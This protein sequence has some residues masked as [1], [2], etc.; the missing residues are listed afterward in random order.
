[1]VGICGRVRIVDGARTC[2]RLGQV[3]ERALL[4]EAASGPLAE[5]T[6]LRR[7]TA[8]WDGEAMAHPKDILAHCAWWMEVAAGSPLLGRI[9]S[10][11]DQGI[12]SGKDDHRISVM[13][14]EGRISGTGRHLPIAW[15]EAQQRVDSAI[16]ASDADLEVDLTIGDRSM[17][18][19]ALTVLR[20][21]V[22]LSYQQAFDGDAERVAE[23]DLGRFDLVP[24]QAFVAVALARHGQVVNNPH[25]LQ[26]LGRHLMFELGTDATSQA[27][28]QALAA[29]DGAVVAW[30][31]PGSPIPTAT[32]VADLPLAAADRLLSSLGTPRAADGSVTFLAGMVPVSL[33]WRDGRLICT[34]HP[35]GSQPLARTGGF[36][37][38]PEIVRALAQLPT[39]TPSVCLL[40]RPAALV[41]AVGPY[42]GMIDAGWSQRT[43]A[44]Q[45]RL[46]EAQ[47]TGWLTI[48][49]DGRQSQVEAAGLLAVIAGGAMVGQA[50]QQG[51]VLRSSN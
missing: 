36:T 32:L 29:I 51:T 31:E 35:A 39:R 41:A 37:R 12:E 7:A 49:D 13:A 4:G 45:Q 48:V 20:D 47:A 22:R 9:Q 23:L 14:A 2:A 42:V 3:P 19:G 40:L 26:I 5:L 30:M 24:E 44:Y 17:G 27:I 28:G 25:D 38:T 11:I 43:L 18:R 50:I 8:V 16:A 6:T 34:T 33:G 15:V 46:I 10:T 21:G 1:M